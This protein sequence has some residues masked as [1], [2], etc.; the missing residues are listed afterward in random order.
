MSASNESFSE[1]LLEYPQYTRPEHF[2]GHDVPQ[3]LLSG[4]HQK[5]ARWR[6]KQ[7]LG[8]TWLTR[9]DLLEKADLSSQQQE[10]LSEFIKETNSGNTN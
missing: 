1:G 10:L 8:R 3:V 4:D 9:P 6:M 5:I 2:T 7:S